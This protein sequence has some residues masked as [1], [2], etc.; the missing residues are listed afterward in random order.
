MVQTPPISPAADVSMTATLSTT[1]DEIQ[2]DLSLET[3][4]I[5]AP[6]GYSP[7]NEDTLQTDTV[8]LSG[9]QAIPAAEDTHIPQPPVE[10][11]PVKADAD[12]GDDLAETVIIRPGT[13]I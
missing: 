12:I 1:V 5:G 10:P 9:T 11:P 3:V 2:D 4:I 7:E 6:G 13:K 8:L